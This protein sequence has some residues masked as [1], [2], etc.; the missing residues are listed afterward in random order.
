MGDHYPDCF[1]CLFC[2]VCTGLLALRVNRTYAQET[3]KDG[4][5]QQY[6]KVFKSALDSA[7]HQP[8]FRFTGGYA[9]YNFNYRSNIDTPYTEKNIVQHN[10]SGQLHVALSG[11]IPLQVN[12]RVRKSNS[13]IF[14]DLASVQFIKTF[15]YR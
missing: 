14:R 1:S 6:T 5:V 8:A 10:I 15:N 13:A 4:V 9:G 11:Y 12:Y 3:R 7:K 2:I